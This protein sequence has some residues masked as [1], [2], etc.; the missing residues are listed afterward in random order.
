MKKIISA[1]TVLCFLLSNVSFA[2]TNLATPSSLDDIAAYHKYRVLAEM[3]FQL[4]LQRTAEAHP[5][6]FTSNPV[7]LNELKDIFRKVQGRDKYI[8]TEETHRHP[9]GVIPC[10]DEM[11][12]VSVDNRHIIRIPIIVRNL[13]G[14]RQDYQ[15][16]FSTI[17]GVP[18]AA[19]MFPVRAYTNKELKSE[20][21]EIIKRTKQNELL[22]LTP[23]ETRAIENYEE[24]ERYDREVIAWVHS[25]ES[26]VEPYE[27]DTREDLSAVKEAA[28]IE[29][30]D[31]DNPIINR[32]CFIV[33]ITSEVEKRLLE[34]K[35]TVTDRNGESR[36]VIAYSHSS[37]HAIHIF[38]PPA[39]FKVIKE[40][41]EAR[42]TDVDYKTPVERNALERMRKALSDEMGAM[43]GCPIE[44]FGFQNEPFNII[45]LRYSEAMENAETNLTKIDRPFKIVD[46]D[47]LRGINS[48]GEI[49]ER[50]Y[51]AGDRTLT[52]ALIS[53]A[54][55]ALKAL[56]ETE[57]VERL[58]PLYGAESHQRGLYV[59]SMRRL[60]ELKGAIAFIANDSKEDIVVVVCD[61]SEAESVRKRLND[62]ETQG[63]RMK[64]DKKQQQV[65]V[66]RFNPTVYRNII[67]RNPESNI[68]DITL[69]MS[70]LRYK[71][72]RPATGLAITPATV[73][74]IFAF[75]GKAQVKRV[76]VSFIMSEPQIGLSD[77]PG[78]FTWNKE[79]FV[80]VVD[81]LMVKMGITVPVTIERD[82]GK[83]A[84]D[85]ASV[86]TYWNSVLMDYT[87]LNKDKDQAGEELDVDAIQKPEDIYKFYEEN[88]ML[89][90]DKIQ[91]A[92]E[93]QKK[94]DIRRGIEIGITEVGKKPTPASHVFWFLYYLYKELEKRGIQLRPSLSEAQIGTIHGYGAEN[95]ARRELLRDDAAMM[96]IFHLGEAAHGTSGTTKE[97]LRLYP[98]LG[99]AHAHIFTDFIVAEF[100]AMLEHNPELFIK[101]SR[102]AL[103]YEK[104]KNA[105][106]K[107]VQSKYKKYND[108]DL[109]I[110]WASY[111]EFVTSGGA[112]GSVANLME[113]LD[114]LTPEQA[115]RRRFAD[116]NITIMWFVLQQ[117]RYLLDQPWAQASMRELT[118]NPAFIES[119]E[120]YVGAELDRFI[121]LFN[122]ENIVDDMAEVTERDLDR[123]KPITVGE[124]QPHDL[125]DTR[126]NELMEIA[127]SDNEAGSVLARRDIEALINIPFIQQNA[128]QGILAKARNIQEPLDVDTLQLL[129]ESRSEIPTAFYRN[130][131]AL[132]WLA[133]LLNDLFHPKQVNF[134]TTSGHIFS[135][136]TTFGSEK[137]DDRL[138][139]GIFLP[140][141]VKSGRNAVVIVKNQKQR[142]IIENLNRTELA[143]YKEGKI[144]CAEDVISARTLLQQ[145]GMRKC[146]YYWVKGDEETEVDI[147][148]IIHIDITKLVRQIIAA[149]GRVCGVV[150]ELPKLYEAARKFAQAA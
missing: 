9:A 56:W 120:R 117:G 22:P 139:L 14:K 75:L 46:I 97:T 134:D 88:I 100:R 32:K 144:L 127:K 94:T 7:D 92:E 20:K 40:K 63:V 12:Y 31:T 5:D 133:R 50:D 67:L 128:S 36:K 115:D 35:V 4:F 108:E 44:L 124:R 28:R 64:G 23:E 126:I 39:Y 148:G 79:D 129:E 99:V 123:V 58:H 112:L 93:I 69:A 149:L 106:E 47:I 29:I 114:T 119:M 59:D 122:N 86:L 57:S 54:E 53:Q 135:E 91:E 70:A 65:M 33:P 45:G 11:D 76:P 132:D 38:L 143:D 30:D 146:Y 52:P 125:I 96:G 104:T 61:E 95:L 81:T 73:N 140:K 10:F 3:G 121:T 85:L 25:T 82:H 41:K 15:I 137:T 142:Q 138:G 66:F 84:E 101:Y 107:K 90:A 103:I 42:Q 102:E 111:E 16:L 87:A 77:K 68:N 71:I 110:N 72:G 6:L 49:Y 83:K 17:K 43:T 60:D 116:S 55:E 118:A 113:E 34:N 131:L 62:T 98:E 141:L 130:G 18:G 51:A 24:Q 147:R 1:I 78:Y 13:E 74:S 27:I 21:E 89:L 8:Y 37:N 80:K 48:H 109:V 19:T 105:F 136:G 2:N 150:E 26:A 145:V